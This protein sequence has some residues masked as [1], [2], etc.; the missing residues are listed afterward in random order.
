MQPEILE[1]RMAGA[2]AIAAVL[3]DLTLEQVDAI[4]N[5]ANVE[6]A[7]GG[8]LAGAIVRRG[9]AVIQEESDRIAPVPVGGAVV[10]GAGDL[11]CRWVIHAVG[12]RW[13]EGQEEQKLRA[14]VQSS[15]SEA[16]RLAARSIALPAIAT[17]IFG[18]PKD[19][20]TRVIVDTVLA[21]IGHHPDTSVRS[22]RLTAS[23]RPTAELFAAALRTAG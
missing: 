4:V 8:G 7:H 23:D 1:K 3:G 9:G 21:W 2:C 6:L 19:A 14:A 13:G 12:P 18:Y 10:T 17:G 15:L 16:D 22:I 11:S 5:A 20:G